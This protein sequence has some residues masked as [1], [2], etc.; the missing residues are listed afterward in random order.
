MNRTHFFLMVL[1]VLGDLLDHPTPLP[2]AGD[3]G[4]VGPWDGLSPTDL[5]NSPL[6]QHDHNPPKCYVALCQ[7]K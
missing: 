4:A 5:L 1:E 2:M 7:A 6:L 3:L